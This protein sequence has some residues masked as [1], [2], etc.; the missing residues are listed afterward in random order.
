MRTNPGPADGIS[1][2]RPL[3]FF[4][5]GAA[6][7]GTTTLF[8]L[9]EGHP[10]LFLPA[11][12]EVPFFT[13]DT[14]YDRGWQRY[15]EEHFATARADQRWGTVTPRYLG[16]LHVPERMHQRCPAARLIALLRNPVDRA[17][18]K[19]RLLMRS[20]GESASFAELVDRQLEPSALARARS[21]TVPLRDALLVRGEYGRLLNTF[22]DRYEP[23]QLL[24]RFTD[25]LEAD[26][27]SVV[28]HVCE[29]IGVGAGWQSPNLGVRAYEGGDSQRFPSATRLAVGNRGLQRAWRVIPGRTRRRINHWYGTELNVRRGARPATVE[30]IDDSTRARLVEFYRA[31]VPLLEALLGRPV[32]WPEFRWS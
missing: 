9:L 22:L 14:I 32:P 11:G 20:S 18:S 31:D 17:F 28:D 27:Q 30:A 6:K 19:Y 24:V 3:D 2:G 7:S 12:K 16:D 21:E 15:L 1:T 23:S 10:Q 5:V 8:R 26:P 25:E 13:K 29:H 4:V